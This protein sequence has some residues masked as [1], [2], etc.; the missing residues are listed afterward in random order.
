MESLQ[1]L[2]TAQVF[3]FILVFARVGTALMMT[4]GYGEQSIPPNIRLVIALA[5][6]F[7]VMPLVPLGSVTPP[8]NL[9]DFVGAIMIEFG[10]GAFIGASA[11]ILFAMLHI[12]GQLAGQSMGLATLAGPTG[13]GFESGAAV[14]NFMVMSGVLMLFVTGL[15]IVMIEAIVASYVLFPMGQV[16]DFGYLAAS[17]ARTATRSFMLAAQFASPFLVLGFLFNLGL[18]LT[19]RMMQ[20]L[21]VFFIGAPFMLA[22]GLLL[23]FACVGSILIAFSNAMG[24]W[25]YSMTG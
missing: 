5:I 4:P 19:N 21:P 2:A 8:S 9:A 10:A 18:G 6:S 3:T 14:A 15:H 1:L 12:G 20:S 25:L 22:G 13:A 11:R 23:L 16:P 7:V 24:D 17:I